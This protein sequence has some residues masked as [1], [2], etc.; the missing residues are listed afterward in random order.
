[1]SKPMYYIGLDAQEKTIG[2]SAKQCADSA[3]IECGESKPHSIR[4]KI[5][6]NLEP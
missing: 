5:A 3:V 4:Q 1:V 2:G 6:I